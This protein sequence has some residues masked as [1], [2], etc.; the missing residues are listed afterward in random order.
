MVAATSVSIAHPRPLAHTD[1]LGFDLPR[2]E[3]I[4]V[5]EHIEGLLVPGVD[6]SGSISLDE[7][8]HHLSVPAKSVL[9]PLALVPPHQGSSGDAPTATPSSQHG[10]PDGAN[11]GMAESPQLC[12]GAALRH[13]FAV[14]ACVPITTGTEKKVRAPARSPMPQRDRSRSPIAA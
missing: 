2:I 9:P 10:T 3:S 4:D 14:S 13:D 7:L 5:S 8:E 12:W 6:D 11:H 1:S